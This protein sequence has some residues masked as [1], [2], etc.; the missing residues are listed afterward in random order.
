LTS[1]VRDIGMGKAYWGGGKNVTCSIGTC[2]EVCH[3]EDL[4]RREGQASAGHR[5]G[6]RGASEGK[7]G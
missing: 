6:A 5:N 7:K 4:G 1:Q 2:R 3:S